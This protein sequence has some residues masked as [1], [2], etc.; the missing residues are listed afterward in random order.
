LSEILKNLGVVHAFSD[1][2]DFSFMDP[3]RN[4]KLSKII[5]KAVIEVNEEGAEASAATG[6]TMQTLSCRI[7]GDKSV[8]MICSHPFLF[9]IT[10][11]P[12]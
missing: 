6:M 12:S 9:S 3:E 10:H 5:H 4:I 11:E 8:S 1:E 2:A 7:G